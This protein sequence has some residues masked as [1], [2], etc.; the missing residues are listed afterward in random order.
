MELVGVVGLLGVEVIDEH[1]DYGGH[2]EDYD[3]KLECLDRG[4]NTKV[5]R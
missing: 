5:F 3:E 2:G 4:G 1:G